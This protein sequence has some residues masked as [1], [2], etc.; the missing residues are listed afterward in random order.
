LFQ[1]VGGLAPC[2]LCLW[3]R[4]PH[5][6]IILLAVCA[7]LLRMPRLVLTGIAITA[8]VSVVL[9]AYHAGVEWRFWAGPGGCTANLDTGG[10]LAS[11][12]D[13]LLATPIVRCDEVAWSFLGLSMAGWNSLFSL[14]IW[15]I[16]LISLTQG[17]KVTS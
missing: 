1:Y 14:D 11:L 17:K 7:P 6:I 15:L 13:S 5:I 2:S 9:A 4:W 8:A 12:T 3:Q 10:D 16:A